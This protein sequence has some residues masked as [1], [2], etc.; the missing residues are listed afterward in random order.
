MASKSS[1]L[2]S[3]CTHFYRY[4]SGPQPPRTAQDIF[5]GCFYD[6][7]FPWTWCQWNVR[8]VDLPPQRTK[9]QWL[10]YTGLQEIEALRSPK[11]Q[12][13]AWQFIEKSTKDY[14][15]S[16]QKFSKQH[17]VVH[18]VMYP[19]LMNEDQYVFQV[20]QPLLHGWDKGKCPMTG[21]QSKG[22]QC[23]AMWRERGHSRRLWKNSSSDLFNFSIKACT[24]L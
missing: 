15:F 23:S 2:R 8:L 22:K 14:N 3:C 17:L 21:I 7:Y 24:R 19:I 5:F 16:F 4:P 20:C 11:R 10:L 18:G 13:W 6:R 1:D 12:S 9:V